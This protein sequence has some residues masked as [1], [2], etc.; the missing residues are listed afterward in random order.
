MIH[1][2]NSRSWRGF[3]L[4][5]TIARWFTTFIWTEYIDSQVGSR[6]LPWGVVMSKEEKGKRMDLSLI[7]LTHRVGRCG[8]CDGWDKWIKL[9]GEGSDPIRPDQKPV[10]DL[11]LNGL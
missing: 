8:L 11:T 1:G 4:L 10:G 3:V 6:P 9:P 5:Y 2:K 7:S